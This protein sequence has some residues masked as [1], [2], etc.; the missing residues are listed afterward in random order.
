MSLDLS[1]LPGGATPRFLPHTSE[2]CGRHALRGPGRGPD[3]KAGVYM[4][5]V[6]RLPLPGSLPN[7]V[8]LLANG[9]NSK[10]LS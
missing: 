1:V 9:L 4:V 6:L 2:P 5:H 7:S 10:C 8:G 3:D